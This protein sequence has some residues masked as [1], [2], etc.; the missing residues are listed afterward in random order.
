M[1][2]TGVHFRENSTNT[3]K[4]SRVQT[5]PIVAFA[6]TFGNIKLNTLERDV[7]VK[8]P[9]QATEDISFTGQVKFTTNEFKKKFNKPV[10]TLKSFNTLK[11]LI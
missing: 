8:E 2:I 3:E 6:Q 9:L 4:V 5:N 10:S 11:F 7:F 1:R